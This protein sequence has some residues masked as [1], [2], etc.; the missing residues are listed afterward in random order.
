MITR[1]AMELAERPSNVMGRR[2]G[3]S[4]SLSRLR[5]IASRTAK[6]LHAN[7]GSPRHGNKKDPLDELVFI[8]LSQM[9]TGPSFNRVYDR[10]KAAYPRW[11]SLLAMPLAKVK[12]V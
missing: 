2:P 5:I 1:R 8:L 7:Y 6:I 3:D 4:R 10:V 12:A 9:T 11:E